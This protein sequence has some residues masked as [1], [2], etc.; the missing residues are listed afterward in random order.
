MNKTLGY[1]MTVLLAGLVL[2]LGAPAAS[3]HEGA[4]K[5][6]VTGDGAQN[7]NVLV[8]YKKDGH[9]VTASVA[10]TLTATSAD[11]RTFGPVTLKSAPEGQ[12]LYHLAEP[13]PSGEWEVT[14][15]ATAPA[16]A[17]KTVKVTAQD[18]AAL[19][20]QAATAPAPLNNAA[21]RGLNNAAAGSE[22]GGDSPI[23]TL[24][25]IGLITLAAAIGVVAWM[26]LTRART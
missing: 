26:R 11:G 12:N 21:P 6:Q 20:Q 23:G 3:A 17:H 18:P 9:P 22:T 19:A 10:A 13:L 25:I 15:N 16:K 24:L 2:L 8:T 7:V 5:L 4:I 14:V 1:V